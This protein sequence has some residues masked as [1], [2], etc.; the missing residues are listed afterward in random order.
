MNRIPALL[1]VAAL[2]ASGCSDDATSSES[3]AE[4]TTASDAA[5]TTASPTTAPA[6][7][8]TNTP[9]STNVAPSAEPWMVIQ[10]DGTSRIELAVLD[11][12][13]NQLAR[14]GRDVPGG[15]QTNPDWSP[16]GTHLAFGVT[17]DDGRDDLWVVNTDGSD[18]QMLYD[19]TDDCIYIDDPAWSPDGTSI[20]MC[21]LTTTADGDLGALATVDVP[22]GELTDIATLAPTDF[23]AGPR[24]SPDGTQIV[25]EIVHRDGTTLDSNVTGVTLTIIDTTTGDTVTELTQPELFAATA[26]WNA[27]TG[28]VVYAALPTPDAAATD[29]FAVNPDSTATRQLTNLTSNGGAAAEPTISADGT[30]V[31]FIAAGDV[32]GLARLDLATDEVTPAFDPTIRAA[33]PRLVP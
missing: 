3:A 21:T 23:C 15:H 6:P 25:A 4:V 22:S 28:E 5:S 33:H 19:C 26:D 16:D 10:V 18:S 11:E 14:P 29:L 27:T 20:A 24:W 2:A 1:V 12:D 31:Y 32:A 8:T 30:T 13:G 9:P 17:A 7:T